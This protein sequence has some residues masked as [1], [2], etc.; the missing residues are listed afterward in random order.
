MISRLQRLWLTLLESTLAAYLVF[1]LT[2]YYQG[3]AYE[4]EQKCSKAAFFD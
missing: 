2:S 4:I 1:L 3:L